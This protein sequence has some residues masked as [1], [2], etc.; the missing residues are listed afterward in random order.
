MKALHPGRVV[1]LRTLRHGHCL[2]AVL[3]QDV[4]KAGHTLTV[5]MLCNKGEDSEEAT[6]SA[7][8]LEQYEQVQP[9]KAVK[10]CPYSLSLHVMHTVAIEPAVVNLVRSLQT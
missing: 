1:L 2:A 6:A 10:V 3:A 9:Y 8:A 7:V 5:L 4:R